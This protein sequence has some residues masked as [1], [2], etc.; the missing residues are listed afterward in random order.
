MN[1][2]TN[3]TITVVEFSLSMHLS[4]SLHGAV[5]I[6]KHTYEFSVTRPEMDITHSAW[7]LNFDWNFHF[8]MVQM[9]VH[10]RRVILYRCKLFTFR[11]LRRKIF[12]IYSHF[13]ASNEWIRFINYSR[14]PKHLSTRVLASRAPSVA[15]WTLIGCAGFF[16]PL[17]F[18]IIKRTVPAETFSVSFASVTN[19]CRQ[20]R[21]ILITGDGVQLA[22][23][24]N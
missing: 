2:F 23:R 15:S 6:F 10:A 16:F 5:D 8:Q 18:Y 4:I 21:E 11:R 22:I 19:V 17:F 14:T 1:K 7:I 13:T 3:R 9:L 24:S 20:S 12:R